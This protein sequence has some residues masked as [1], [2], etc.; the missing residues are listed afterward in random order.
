MPYCWEADQPAG[1]KAA[2]SVGVPQLSVVVASIYGI[3]ELEVFLN[4]VSGQILHESVE[5]IV[6]LWCEN[7]VLQEL[8]AIF[9]H[10][11]FIQFAKGTP[12]PD[13]WGAGIKRSTGKIIA[14]TDSTCIPDQHWI[15][16]VLKAHESSHPVIGGAVEIDSCDRLV[17]WAAY[18]C[19]YGQF[20]H[21]LTEGV[22]GE[23]PG[24]NLSFKR[25]ALERGK[26]FVRDG[27]WKTYW[28]QRLKEEG[29]QLVSAPSIV[30]RYRK[31][32]TL[33]PFLV[34]RFHHGRC[35]AGMRV[36]RASTL[37]RAFYVAGTPLLPLL[38]L[39]RLTKV[40]A[41]KRRY[42]RQFALSFPIALLA[43]VS[44]SFGE[45]LGYVV[46]TG[47]SCARVY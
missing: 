19:E 1:R 42:L 5:I 10:S 2:H 37:K 35:F 30:V 14:I 4:A 15:C 25:A 12:L 9:P 8:K 7:G 16:S 22:V 43:I 17:D 20:M 32:F 28:C 21:P 44:W 26:E 29:I 13:L 46:G 47:T 27:F 31:T 39:V 38:F 33:L 41:T 23:L 40:V 11:T 18:F 6:S 24:N 45:L 36:A 3:P 34:R